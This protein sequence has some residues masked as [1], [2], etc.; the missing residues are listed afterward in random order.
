VRRGA[1]TGWDAPGSAS[2]NPPRFRSCRVGGVPGHARDPDRASRRTVT[3]L[4]ILQP[5]SEPVVK[6]LPNRESFC[7]SSYVSGPRITY[8]PM[9]LMMHRP[10]DIPTA[11]SGTR[12]Q[13]DAHRERRQLSTII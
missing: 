7:A 12:R 3:S 2:S 5:A 1:A 13:A 6:E 4:Q 9:T 10:A 11:S 8:L